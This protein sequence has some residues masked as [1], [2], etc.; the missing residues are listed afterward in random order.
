MD[1]AL[2]RLGIP[3][4][5]SPLARRARDLIADVAPPSLL[6]HSVRVYAW[7][8]DLAGRDG[9]AFDSEILYVAAML[10][11]LGLIPP[12][13]LGGC[14]DAD[15][16]IAAASLAR[17][18][19]ATADRV[20]VIHDAIALHNDEELPPDTAPEVVLIWDAAGVDVTGERYGDVRP[21]L[22]P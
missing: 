22:I 20:R 9:L 17:D 3:V 14:Y 4:P 5:A 11:D 16:A 1:D 10:H 19:G 13:D 7:A 6:N 12:Y 15:G 21:A 18:A 8:V 2:I